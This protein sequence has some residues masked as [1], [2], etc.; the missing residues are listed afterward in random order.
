PDEAVRLGGKPPPTK[1]RSGERDAEPAGEGEERKPGHVDR[2]LHKSVRLDA[3]SPPSGSA[4]GRVCS[5]AAA[6]ALARRA[7]NHP[8]ACAMWISLTPCPTCCSSIRV[9]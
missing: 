9:G 7:R 5:S 4:Q 3:G 6:L 8:S 1:E 2:H